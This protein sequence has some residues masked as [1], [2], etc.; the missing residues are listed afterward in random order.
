MI[1]EDPKK[2]QAAV[3][4]ARAEARET[5]IKAEKE[6]RAAARRKAEEAEK[7][8]IAVAKAK[9]EEADRQRKEAQG[10][11]VMS[12]HI[13]GDP[14]HNLLHRIG[15]PLGEREEGYN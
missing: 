11:K 14:S 7:E 9:A 12:T 15:R 3:D 8:R 6:R 2:R 1:L 10:A 13:E 4:A 5:A